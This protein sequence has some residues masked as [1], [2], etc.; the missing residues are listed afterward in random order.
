M[1]PSLALRHRSIFEDPARFLCLCSTVSLWLIPEVPFALLLLVLLTLQAGAIRMAL[2]GAAPG[3]SWEGGRRIHGAVYASVLSMDYAGLAAGTAA[4]ALLLVRLFNGP[5]PVGALSALA[6]GVCLLPDIRLCRRL[7]SCDPA[8]ASRQL[9]DGAFYRDPVM[10]GTLLAAGTLLLMDLETLSYV[11]ASLLLFQAG[12][13]LIFV[14]QYL[15]E[16]EVRRWTGPAA[17]LLEREGRRILLPVGALLLAPLRLVGGE[18]AAMGG[19]SLLLLGVLL[20]DLIRLGQ[21]L[22][23]RLSDLLRVTPSGMPTKR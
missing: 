7:L 8:E 21:G 22:A 4:G 9:R 20:P 1:S 10:L 5:E 2:R 6:A 15:P 16:M 14:D 23:V 18:S 17:L 3:W 13:M 11:L 19:L 12:P